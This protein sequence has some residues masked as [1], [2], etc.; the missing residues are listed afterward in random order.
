M[1]ITVDKHKLKKDVTH[2]FHNNSNLISYQSRLSQKHFVK[3]MIFL[4]GY[5]ACLEVLA[6]EPLNVNEIHKQLQEEVVKFI[7][8][9]INEESK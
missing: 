7:V 1:K 5:I 9:E 3:A 2:T 4:K 6:E 8:E